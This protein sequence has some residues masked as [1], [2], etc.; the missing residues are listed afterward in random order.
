MSQYQVAVAAEGFAAALFARADLTE[1]PKVYI[2]TVQE[3]AA[4]LR[5]SGGGNGDTVLHVAKTWKTGKR[6]GLTD[7]IPAGWSFRTH[8]STK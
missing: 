2:A 4:H 1:M 8:E 6:Q 5:Q 3:V 7:E